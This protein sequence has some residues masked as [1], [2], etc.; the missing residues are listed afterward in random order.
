MPAGVGGQV[1]AAP[2]ASVVWI[3]NPVDMNTPLKVERSRVMGR[4][5]EEEAMNA[6][7]DARGVSPSPSA[8][9]PF[10]LG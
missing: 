10:L 9:Q 6:L 4:E 8:H 5:F 1:V 7:W 2:E 3:A